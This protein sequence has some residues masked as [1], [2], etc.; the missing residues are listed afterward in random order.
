[1]AQAF[2]EARNNNNNNNKA[3]HAHHYKDLNQPLES[4]SFTHHQQRRRRKQLRPEVWL[5]AMYVVD[6]I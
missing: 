1:M 5:K 6:G 4:L 3:Y 2:G